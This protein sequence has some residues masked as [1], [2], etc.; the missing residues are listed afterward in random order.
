VAMAALDQCEGEI[1]QALQKDGWEVSEKPYAIRIVGR[2]IF[3]DMSLKRIKGGEH[4]EII[5]V[6]VKCFTNPSADLQELY[7]A[8]GQYHF[9]RI[10]LT[11][12][13]SS[14][15]LYLAIPHQ[16]YQRLIKQP[17]ISALFQS[18]G[19]KLVVVDIEQEEI[20]QWIS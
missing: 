5:I 15:P 3:A 2:S 4:E 16:A 20:V 11:L 18:G 17:S 14:L 9:Y 1:I 19:V 7:T 10:A 8:I 6:E 12:K 13:R